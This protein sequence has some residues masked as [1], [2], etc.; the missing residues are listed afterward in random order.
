MK[1]LTS[2]NKRKIINSSTVQN[3]NHFC[4]SN[5]LL[6][7]QIRIGSAGLVQMTLYNGSHSSSLGMDDQALTFPDRLEHVRLVSNSIININTLL[8]CHE[9]SQ[10]LDVVIAIFHN[11]YTHNSRVNDINRCKSTLGSPVSCSVR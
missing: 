10:I 3:F 8:D 11:S 5:D 9:T 7:V 1:T 4:I 6:I 2:L